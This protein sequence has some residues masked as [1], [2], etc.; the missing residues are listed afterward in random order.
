MADR[1]H[2]PSDTRRHTD[3][4]KERRKDRPRDI[5]LLLS[6]AKH[7]VIIQTSSVCR[8]SSGTSAGHSTITCLEIAIR[9]EP[10]V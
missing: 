4:R 3:G 1:I 2:T 5:V 7:A 6:N 8:R 10:A 9:D